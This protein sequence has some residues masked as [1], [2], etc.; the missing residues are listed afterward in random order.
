MTNKFG[1]N[2]SDDRN[3]ISKAMLV[4]KPKSIV[5]KKFEKANIEKPTEIVA[6]V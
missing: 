5:G 1:N 6:A 3:E 4:N 2:V